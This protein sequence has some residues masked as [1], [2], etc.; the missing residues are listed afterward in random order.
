MAT[1][2]SSGQK[3]VAEI[4]TKQLQCLKCDCTIFEAAQKLKSHSVGCIPVFE[5]DMK[6]LVGVVTD[7][8]IVVRCVAEG[9]DPKTTKL[10]DIMSTNLTCVDE[11]ESIEKVAHVMA[12]HQLRRIFVH[13]KDKQFAGIV[14]LA[15]FA[16]NVTDKDVL[17]VALKAETA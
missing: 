8:D 1:T 9:K 11:N 13:G 16:A 15:D 2:S 5:N 3:K 10:R 4:M 7:R 12:K 14:S 6:N 17:C